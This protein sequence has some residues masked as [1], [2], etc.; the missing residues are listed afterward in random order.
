MA[1]DPSRPSTAAPRRVIPINYSGFT[2]Y[3]YQAFD[4]KT[5]ISLKN[6]INLLLDR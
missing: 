3:I 5:D 2:I 1:M 4:P 6:K